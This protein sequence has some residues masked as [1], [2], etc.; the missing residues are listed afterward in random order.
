MIYNTLTESSE[1]PLLLRQ[2]LNK[3]YFGDYHG[4]DRLGENNLQIPIRVALRTR[5]NEQIKTRKN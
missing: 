1:K 4:K 2:S 5:V 3:S